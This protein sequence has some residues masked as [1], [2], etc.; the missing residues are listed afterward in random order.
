MAVIQ[1]LINIRLN[2]VLQICVNLKKCIVIGQKTVN[3]Q[4]TVQ[5]CLDGSNKVLKCFQDHP[6][7]ILKCSNLV[8]EFSNCV[9]NLHYTRVIEARS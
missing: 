6:E 1:L 2:I 7:E 4:G 8:E 5:P 3:V 9:W